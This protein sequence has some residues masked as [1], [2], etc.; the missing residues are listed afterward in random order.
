[1]AESNPAMMSSAMTTTILPV[2]VISCMIRVV[3]A[4]GEGPG[5]WIGVRIFQCAY[6]VELARF[7]QL[8]KRIFFLVKE[9]GFR[10]YVA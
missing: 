10:L 7:V 8:K 2:F 6:T 5:L 4:S 1:M 3:V 9:R